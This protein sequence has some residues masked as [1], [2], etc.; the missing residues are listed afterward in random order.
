MSQNVADTMI[1]NAKD[2]SRCIA[3]TDTSLACASGISLLETI[4]LLRN[5][6]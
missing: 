6:Y 2:T 3:R 4:I 5:K 1:Y